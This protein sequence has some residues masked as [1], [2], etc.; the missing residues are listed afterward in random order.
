MRI[1]GASG[2]FERQ[3][4]IPTPRHTTKLGNGT[5]LL[6]LEVLTL[7]VCTTQ[8]DRLHGWLSSPDIG[9]YVCVAVPR[10][11]PLTV[12]SGSEI[13]KLYQRN[14]TKRQKKQWIHDGWLE[15]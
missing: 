12:K 13:G 11:L 4:Q 9:R 14:S 5:H 2:S 7:V 6:C 8:R 3:S 15:S 1:T 10:E